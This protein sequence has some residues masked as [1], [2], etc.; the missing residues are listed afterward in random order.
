M[1]NLF[2]FA[3]VAASALGVYLVANKETPQQFFKRTTSFALEKAEQLQTFNRDRAQFND[4]LN[5]FKVELTRSQKAIRDVQTRIDEYSFEIKPHLD[6][7]NQT[8]N[9]M[10]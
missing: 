10:K 2:K 9:Q 7:I 1:R 6:K 8:L 3:G 4:A 5:K